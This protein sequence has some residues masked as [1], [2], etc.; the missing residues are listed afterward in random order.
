MN[1]ESFYI[2]LMVAIAII[3][4]VFLFRIIK[5]P[6]IFDRLIGLSGLST[7][8]ILLLVVIGAHYGQLD[9]FID[10]AIGYGLLNLVS[11]L[12]TGKYLE[13]KAVKP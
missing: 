8:A 12:A 5:G 3:I 10:I 11:S 7:K 13:S 2:L 9:M 1:L 4:P 6:T